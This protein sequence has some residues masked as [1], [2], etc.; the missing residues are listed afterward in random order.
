M[1]IVTR[2]IVSCDGPSVGLDC[3]ASATADAGTLFD[4]R[5]WLRRNG[6]TWPHSGDVRLDLCPACSP[7]AVLAPHQCGRP[8]KALSRDTVTA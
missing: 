3:E 1:A 2:L 7:R 8:R 5:R 4:L 6:W